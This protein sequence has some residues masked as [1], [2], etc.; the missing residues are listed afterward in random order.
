ALGRRRPE[1]VGDGQEKNDQRLLI[2]RLHCQDIETDDLCGTGVVDHPVPLRFLQR[3]G[4]A[5]FGDRFGLEGHSR[6][7]SVLSRQSS[8]V[9]SRSLLLSC[10]WNLATPS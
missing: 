8:V 9:S 6:Q 10:R 2:L 5:F 1:L 4:D 3:G 7:S